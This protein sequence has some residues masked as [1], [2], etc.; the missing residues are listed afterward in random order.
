MNDQN[1]DLNRSSAS[2]SIKWHSING[3]QYKPYTIQKNVI[4]NNYI[5]KNVQKKTMSNSMD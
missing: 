1:K 4:N 2:R 3:L 5:V